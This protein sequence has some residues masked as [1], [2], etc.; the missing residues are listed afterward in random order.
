[1]KKF[2][3]FLET[4]QGIRTLASSKGAGIETQTGSPPVTCDQI[5]RHQQSDVVQRRKKKMHI[6]LS[7]FF[8]RLSLGCPYTHTDTA[9]RMISDSLHTANSLTSRPN[10]SIQPNKKKTSAGRQQSCS[11]CTAF[12]YR[13]SPHPYV[14]NLSS[15][16]KEILFFS[17]KSKQDRQ[18]DL[19]SWLNSL[20]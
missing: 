8:L 13:S 10:I 20:Q 3:Y 15:S 1:V 11:R 7:L 6:R 18:S 12:H 9:M 2:K 5:I 14:L 17:I 19:I 4:K 16:K